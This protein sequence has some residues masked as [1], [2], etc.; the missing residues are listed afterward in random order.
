M[1]VSLMIDHSAFPIYLATGIFCFR[2]LV[3]NLGSQT[4]CGVYMSASLNGWHDFSHRRAAAGDRLCLSEHL[5]SVGRG[6]NH[7]CT[8]GGY[9]ASNPL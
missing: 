3:S 7:D 9:L 1:S 8:R 6:S 2:G 4:A 5:A